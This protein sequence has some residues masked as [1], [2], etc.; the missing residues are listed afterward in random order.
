MD[1][2]QK[3]S[4]TPCNAKSLLAFTFGLMGRLDRG[5]IDNNTAVAQ[6]KL[7]SQAN[8]IMKNEILRTALQ[9]KM[10]EAHTGIQAN[11]IRIREIESKSFDDSKVT[12][13]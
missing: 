2:E 10:Y 11:E 6:A 12:E 13:Q 3:L 1:S 5:E 9:L 7:I 8:N 4:G